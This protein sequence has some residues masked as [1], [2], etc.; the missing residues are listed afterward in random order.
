[1]IEGRGIVG[2]WL[3]ILRELGERPDFAYGRIDPTSDSVLEWIDFHHEDAD[4]AG[5]FTAMLRQRG[6]DVGPIPCAKHPRPR[7][8]AMLKTFLRNKPLKGSLDAPWKDYDPAV[9]PPEPPRVPFMLLTVEETNALSAAAKAKGVSLNSLLLHALNEA[10]TPL[11]V[12]PSRPR[13]WFIPVN[14]RGADDEPADDP[15]NHASF[16]GCRI[17]NG[18]DV[19]AVHEAIRA[20]LASNAHWANW[21]R[22]KLILG[23][24]RKRVKKL[25]TK[26]RE[27]RRYF[28]GNFS[29]MGE[30]NPSGGEADGADVAWCVAPPAFSDI[31]ISSVVMIW[32]GRLSAGFIAH[33]GIADDETKAKQVLDRWREA[34][35]SKI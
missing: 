29:N 5:S 35:L 21:M 1:M 13:T 20:Q 33:P 15:G 19:S 25:L 7:G 3:S 22:F 34:L 27:R 11:L 8:L 2:R 16:I 12:D 14:I 24:G 30:W 10:I 26:G 23:L 6:Y 31:A 4:G 18:A 28:E 17:E 9:P 32:R